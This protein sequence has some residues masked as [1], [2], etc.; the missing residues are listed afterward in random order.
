MALKLHIL[1]CSTRPTR[2]GPSVARWFGSYAK[3]DG[4]FETVLVDLKDFD[5]PVYDEPKHPRMQQYEHEHTRRWSK[6]VDAADAFVFVSP[7]Y[8]YGPTPALLNALTYLVREWAYKP[9]GFVS[10]G[11]V[12]GGIRGVQ[13]IKTI[14]TTL[15]LFPLTEGVMVPLVQTMISEDGTFRPTPIMEEGAGIM[16]KELHRVAA[17]MKPLREA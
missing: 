6:S 2:V 17:A 12:S 8:N 9:V 1:I 11:G 15:K 4:A 10:Y 14:M 16:L 5:L 7:E 3:A 13:A